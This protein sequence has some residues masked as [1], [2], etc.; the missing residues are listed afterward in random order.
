[1]AEVYLKSLKPAWEV[2]SAGV[3][4]QKGKPASELAKLVVKSQSLDLSAH[5]SRPVDDTLEGVDQVWVMSKRHL[6]SFPEG[7]AELLTSVLGQEKDIADPF[8]GELGDYRRAF[9]E[10]C[11]CVD[12]LVQVNG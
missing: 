11:K 1:M 10:I 7:E 8:G 4:A 9:E 6:R 12:A 3:Q 2:G 5:R